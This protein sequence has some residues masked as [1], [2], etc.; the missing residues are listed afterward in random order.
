MHTSYLAT[1]SGETN[2][3]CRIS[4]SVGANVLRYGDTIAKKHAS[5]LKEPIG[6]EFLALCLDVLKQG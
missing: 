3:C 6:V 5:K 4:L 2:I 1:I